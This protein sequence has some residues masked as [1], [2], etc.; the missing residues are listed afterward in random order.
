MCNV[1]IRFLNWSSLFKQLSTLSSKS[2]AAYRAKLAWPNTNFHF[3]IDW[4]SI[5]VSVLPLGQL[6][7]HLGHKA[8]KSPK[9]T[10][11]GYKTH[12]WGGHYKGWKGII[13]YVRNILWKNERKTPGEQYFY[14]KRAQDEQ[15]R[16]GHKTVLHWPCS[17]GGNFNNCHLQLWLV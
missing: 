3:L 8:K 1:K 13:C 15:L 6:G 10:K 12:Q 4:N 16:L 7:G 5:A 17:I 11:N 9:I 2:F 14:G